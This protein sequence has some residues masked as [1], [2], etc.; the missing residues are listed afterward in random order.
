MHRK[1]PFLSLS[2]FTWFDRPG[3]ADGSTSRGAEQ[4]TRA[5][6][7]RGAPGT[8]PAKTPLFTHACGATEPPGSRDNPQDP[9]HSHPIPATLAGPWYPRSSPATPMDTGRR[10]TLGMGAQTTRWGDRGYTS[11]CFRHGFVGEGGTKHP[12]STQRGWL[13]GSGTVTP[14]ER[15]AKEEEGLPSRGERTRR[16]A[17]R[18][19]EAAVGRGPPGPGQEPGPERPLTELSDVVGDGVV[20]LAPLQGGGRRTPVTLPVGG[21]SHCGARSRLERS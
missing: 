15:G 3:W 4:P 9:P 19:K 1:I 11:P 20:L 12:F 18:G 21:R 14:E 5:A 16:A 7:R 2:S 10:D 8:T 6:S 13:R 17:E